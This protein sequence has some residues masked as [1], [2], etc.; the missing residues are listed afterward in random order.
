MTGLNSS[1]KRTSIGRFAAACALTLIASVPVS[2]VAVASPLPQTGPVT[3]NDYVTDPDGFLDSEQ[4][5]EIRDAAM[6]ARSSGLSPYFVIVP[7]FSG[8]DPTDWCIASANRSSMS[9]EAVVFA[10]AYQERD[11]GWC[12]SLPENNGIITDAQI[13]D[14]W[15]SSLDV[16][17]DSDPLEGQ[18]ATDAA[19]YFANELESAAAGGGS[20]SGSIT[21]TTS[22]SSGGVSIW[23]LLVFFVV[24]ALVIWAFTRRSKKKAATS[25]SATQAMS[26]DE[27]VATAKQQ[28]LYSDEA[29]RDAEDDVQFAKA[30]FGGA[31]TDQFANAV[32]VARK[33]I[34]DAFT[35][36]PRLDDTTSDAEKGSIAAQIMQIVGAVMPPVK[37]AQDQLQADR[38]KEVQ[39]E[40]R[41]P[42]LRARVAE[43]RADVPREQQRLQDLAVRFTPIQLQSLQNK[44][45]QAAAFLDTAERYLSDAQ[46]Q[47]LTNRASAVQSL[48]SAANQ[49][50]LALS[51]L[52]N[53]KTAERTIGESDRVLGA[54]IASITQDLSDVTRLA[55]NQV[56]FAPLVSDANAAVAEGQAA[57]Q[58]NADPL[59]AL[60]HLRQAED[61]LDQALAPL[62]SAAD[63]N[64]RL[65]S[66][67]KER[68]A[69]AEALVR[70]A[71]S[72]SQTSR[73]NM[74]LNARSAVSN[75][76][77]QLEQARITLD[78]SPQQSIN[79]STQAEQWARNALAEMQ[80]TPTYQPNY[81]SGGSNSMLWG[82]LLG[83][84][85]GGSGRGHSGGYRTGG[86]GGGG[87]RSSG[88]FGG[89]GGFRGSGGS[90][91]GFR[92]GGGGGG[93][94]GGGGGRSGKF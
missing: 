87:Y 18:A 11:T 49:L 40:S 55:S 26:L 64:S 6:A 1:S 45:Q 83:Q 3:I 85:M 37:A 27:Q 76:M 84:M 59:G 7:D 23:V 63:Q 39:A 81:Q 10:L 4:V 35:L 19:V 88:G 71:Q 32:Q 93:F 92:G 78:S 94:R 46:S 66:Q 17:R 36:L 9:S 75:A 56:A 29:L 54:A 42:D 68:Y 61:A 82:M 43:A 8:N 21:P 91:G 70:Q 20:S 30:Q 33:G 62:R 86:F 24:I 67:A 60:D 28:L 57:R 52:E 2:T 53:I 48:D 22:S 50:S 58:G 44:P 41:L 80:A 72:M 73:G 13:D 31:R 51:A 12:T 15:Y 47:L 69:A 38:D 25:T 89:S 65:A 74:S 16:I 14:I 5:G 77:A 79:S 34:T 90:S